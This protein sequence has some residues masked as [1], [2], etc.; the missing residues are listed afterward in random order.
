MV[1][2]A[3]LSKL[4]IIL[5]VSS[6]SPLFRLF[7]NVV[8]LN[9]SF[10]VDVLFCWCHFAY[11]VLFCQ[12]LFSHWLK[13]KTLHLC[14]HIKFCLPFLGPFI[15]S[16][17][18][19]L[20]GRGGSK[21]WTFLRNDGL[22]WVSVCIIRCAYRIRIPVLKYQFIKVWLR[23]LNVTRAAWTLM[24][25]ARIHS[26]LQGSSARPSHFLDAETCEFPSLSMLPVWH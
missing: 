6:R 19:Y 10:C 4:C 2:S 5:C 3:I 7:S 17:N 14:V 23:Y 22:S 21:R 26:Q 9:M 16:V 18:I 1:S 11:F 24:E 15:G 25:L 12:M 20:Q 8:S 13:G